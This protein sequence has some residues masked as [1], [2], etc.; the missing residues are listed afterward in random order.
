GLVA[1]QVERLERQHLGKTHAGWPLERVRRV[2][3]HLMQKLLGG[4]SAEVRADLDVLLLCENLNAHSLAYLTDRP[5]PERLIE[6]LQRIEETLTDAAEETPVVPLGVCLG[7]GPAID[8]RAA[9]PAGGFAAALRAA[10]QREV[11]ALIARGP[12]AEWGCPAPKP[13]RA[14]PALVTNFT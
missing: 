7:V 12:P 5:T 9:P 3:H 13:G 1:S 4:P 10:M 11:D 14:S 8:L 6:T 2:R